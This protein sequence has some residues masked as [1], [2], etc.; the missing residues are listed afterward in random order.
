MLLGA[1]IAMGRRIT[2][3]NFDNPL[4]PEWHNANTVYKS[5]N[6]TFREKRWPSVSVGYI[7]SSQLTVIGGDVYETHYQ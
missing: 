2:K 1:S 4:L 3:S 6:A 5:L 7:P